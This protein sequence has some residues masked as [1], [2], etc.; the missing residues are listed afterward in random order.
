MTEPSRM[1]RQ[2]ARSTEL[3][4]RFTIGSMSL[5]AGCVLVVALALTDQSGNASAAVT[6]SGGPTF[7]PKKAATT[8]PGATPPGS[9]PVASVDSE[10][11]PV[12]PTTP[13]VAGAPPGR[14]GSPSTPANPGSGSTGSGAVSTP[15]AL[16]PPAPDPGGG[17]PPTAPPQSTAP[18]APPTTA[19]PATAPPTTAPPP[20]T[21]PTTVSGPS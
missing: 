10:G 9:D 14:P 6:T 21:P 8:V 4:S 17:P 16:T 12:D 2:P 20:T 3:R 7:T 5:G 15:S 13:D 11:V 19:P 18:T 1:G